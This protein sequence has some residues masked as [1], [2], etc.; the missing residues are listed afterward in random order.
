MSNFIDYRH[1]RIPS[2]T[3]FTQVE[4]D[5]GF[6]P[7]YQFFSSNFY[8]LFLYAIRPIRWSNQANDVHNGTAFIG[9][10]SKNRNDFSINGR[11]YF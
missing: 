11:G 2:I 5:A 7:N 8:R 1:L 10:Y 6:L 9:L 3:N 4:M